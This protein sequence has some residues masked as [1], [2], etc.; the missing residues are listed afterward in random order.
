MLMEKTQELERI[1]KELLGYLGFD[2]TPVLSFEENTYNVSLSAGKDSA[3]LIGYHGETLNSIQVVISL[4]LFRKFNEALSV[5]VDVDGYRKERYERL[6][7]LAVRPSDKARFLNMPQTL[8]AMNAFERRLIHLFVSEVV[9]DM[10]SESTGEGRDRQV[11]IRPK[12]LID[13][14]KEIEKGPEEDLLEKLEDKE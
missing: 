13:N 4:I 5:I 7:A 12:S 14:Q 8:P 11:V 9:P 6:K 3:L 2:L 1:V 10:K